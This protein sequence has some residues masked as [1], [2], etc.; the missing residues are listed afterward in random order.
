MGK[1]KLERHAQEIV[2]GLWLGERWACRYAREA[3]LK[4]ICVLERPCGVEDCFHAPILVLRGTSSLN[5][6]EGDLTNENKGGV[7][8]CEEHLLRQAHQAIDN[9]LKAGP[10]LVHC[11]RVASAAP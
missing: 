7:I 8:R 5:D 10:V 4:G 11:L 3:G 6:N 9:F 1:S 2:P